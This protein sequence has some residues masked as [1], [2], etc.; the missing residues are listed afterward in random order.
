MISHFRKYGLI[1]MVALLYLSNTGLA[2]HVHTCLHS[3]KKNIEWIH[4]D[5]DHNGC[6]T[7]AD[8]CTEDGMECCSKTEAQKKADCHKHSLEF[9]KLTFFSVKPET[10]SVHDYVAIIPHNWLISFISITSTD[11]FLDSETL[12]DHQY[13][14]R[15]TVRTGLE[16]RIVLSSFIC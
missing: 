3:G 7:M 15:S 16:Q 14:I 2:Y 5:S 4:T 13:W 8:N 1:V 10:K 11:F 9:K 12:P 6:A